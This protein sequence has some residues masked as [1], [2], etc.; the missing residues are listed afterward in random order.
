MVDKRLNINQ[1]SCNQGVLSNKNWVMKW[2]GWGEGFWKLQRVL[3]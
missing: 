1:F 2:L 3:R